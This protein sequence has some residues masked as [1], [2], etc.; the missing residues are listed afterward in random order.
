MPRQNNFARVTPKTWRRLLRETAEFFAA[1]PWE[2]TYD[3]HIVGLTDP[4]TGEIHI[5]SV[6]GNA[7]LVFGATFHRRASGLNWIFRA[8]G[9]DEPEDLSIAEGMDCL[10]LE[11]VTKRELSKEELHSLSAAGFKTAE[12]GRA[13]PRFLSFEPGWKPW[14]INEHE[15]GQFLVFLRIWR[16]GAP[17]TGASTC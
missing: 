2:Y 16:R 1:K 15:A 8:I 17:L 7:G 12:R 3:S 10:K 5:G 13:W 9:N 11:F 6:L 4:T 14:S